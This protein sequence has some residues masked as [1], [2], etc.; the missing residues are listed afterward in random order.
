MVPV[1][2]PVRRTQ[3][4]CTD[5]GTHTSTH[6]LLSC[7]RGRSRVHQQRCR[8][9]RNAAGLS[10][11]RRDRRGPGERG[12]SPKGRVVTLTADCQRTT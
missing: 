5:A 3:L 10:V 2:L 1:A 9:G 11:I 7:G 4:G 12:V 8:F 6:A